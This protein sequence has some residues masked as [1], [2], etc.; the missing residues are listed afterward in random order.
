[1]IK[2]CKKVFVSTFISFTHPITVI[3]FLSFYFDLIVFSTKHLANNSFLLHNSTIVIIENFM[4]SFTLDQ[5]VHFV[6]I[7]K[8]ILLI[9]HIFYPYCSIF[10][11]KYTGQEEK[12]TQ[13]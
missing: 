8:R 7:A 3:L 5:S 2:M 13:L 11:V 1:M 4:F 12:E 6:V 9:V 10:C